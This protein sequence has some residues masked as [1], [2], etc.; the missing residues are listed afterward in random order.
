MR[1]GSN[2]AISIRTLGTPTEDARSLLQRYRG[3][4]VLART[5]CWSA[6]EGEGDIVDRRLTTSD[7][8]IAPPR[9]LVGQLPESYREYFPRLER[10]QDGWYLMQPK[11]LVRSAAKWRLIWPRAEYLSATLVILPHEGEAP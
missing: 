1:E 10:R 9:S 6:G 2:N 5:F 11:G 4:T 8:H 7:C 3:I